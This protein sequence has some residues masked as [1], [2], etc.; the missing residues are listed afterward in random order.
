MNL[1]KVCIVTILLLSISTTSLLAEIYFID[2]CLVKTDSFYVFPQDHST[3]A[4]RQENTETRKYCCNEEFDINKEF[5]NKTAYINNLDFFYI[6]NLLP[7]VYN[8]PPG[9]AQSGQPSEID[10]ITKL[11]YLLNSSFLI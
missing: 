6:K 4:F 3:V 1:S 11:I 2:T 9:T 8:N 7:V 10:N 5:T